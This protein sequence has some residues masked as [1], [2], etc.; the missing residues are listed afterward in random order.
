LFLSQCAA[1]L[2]SI[3]A[4]GSVGDVLPLISLAKGLKRASFHIRFCVHPH[5]EPLVRESDLGFF[6]LSGNAPQAVVADDLRK[7]SRTPIG[8]LVRVLTRK[9]R[10]RD[11]DIERIREGCLGSDA[12]I[13]T[14]M[15]WIAYHFAEQRGIPAIGAY[16]HP[17]WPT[18][19]FPSPIG[20]PPLKLG[21]GYNRLTHL[22]MEQLF[23]LNICRW[24]NDWRSS[25][26]LPRI[27]W[28]GV[29]YAMQQ[30]GIPIL[31]GISRFWF[32]RP[33]DWPDWLHVVGY[34]VEPLPGTYEPEEGLAAFIAGGDRPISIG[35]GSVIDQRADDALSVILEA[36]R[37][38]N[39]RAVL[40][41]GW[42][43]Y[44]RKLPDSVYETNYVPHAWLFGKVSAAIHAAGV[45]TVAQVLTAGVPSIP[46]PFHSEQKFNASRLHQ[47]GVAPKPI[48]RERLSIDAV[49]EALQRVS[50]DPSY[51][52]RGEVISHLVKSENGIENA[53][54]IIATILREKACHLPE[55]EN[56]TGRE[57]MRNGA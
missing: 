4:G 21:R 2:I 51:R 57:H 23:W 19:R 30:R 27:G 26:G 16:L 44:T 10:P 41:S 9:S 56:Q 37:A 38:A 47:L 54:R 17:T 20:L 35:F 34:W 7:R 36:L 46:I 52:I 1:M 15:S 14:P 45:S 43:R 50:G 48:P 33:E 18:S 40:V 5:F 13:F 3:F 31:F 55:E 28:R 42:N 11:E 39:Q 32:E 49:R 53:V 8:K 6:P 29:R 22:F 24:L 12:L 25:I